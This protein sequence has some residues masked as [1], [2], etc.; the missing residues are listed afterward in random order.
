MAPVEIDRYA[1]LLVRVGVN[2]EAGQELFVDAFVEHA[3]LARAVARAGYAAG[4]K[5][6]DVHYDDKYVNAAL[7]ELASSEEIERGASWLIGRAGEIEKRGG[8]LI[9]IAGD[10]AP[11]LLDDVDPERVAIPRA[12]DLTAE[13]IRVALSDKVRWTIAAYPTEG[14]A[15]RMLGSP[16]VER[17]WDAIAT[18]VRLD[19]DDPSRAWREHL[20]RLDARTGALN[21]LT[22]DAVRFHGAG[23]DFVVGLLPQSLWRYGSHSIE[24]RP[25]VANMPTE[26]VFVTPDRTRADGVV[27]STRPLP[28][29]GTVVEGLEM[30][31]REGKI[32]GVDA[33]KAADVVRKQVA[34]DEGA[35]RLGEVALVD[36]GSR[37]GQTGLTFF[38]TLFDENAACHIAYGQS[39]GAV[40]DDAAELDAGAQTKLGI[41]QSSVHTDFM[42]GG[43]EIDVDG[44]TADGSVV[45][46]LRENVWQLA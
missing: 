16:D 6:V 27:R 30:R 7:V 29:N 31:F 14:W 2:L 4:A 13:R 40:S 8:A 18:C 3:P 35:A 23:T 21:E 26:E 19:E 41:N 44:I 12:R 10:P 15:E 9:S 33:E 37:V 43:P 32:V 11:R 46:L 24:G 36:A 38:N 42:I 22:L 28:L 17:L 20:A 1:E 45:P 5:R 25:F 39:A 34:I